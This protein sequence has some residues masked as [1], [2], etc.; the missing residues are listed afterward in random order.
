MKKSSVIRSILAI[1]PALLLPSFLPGAQYLLITRE[2]QY[3]R[4]IDVSSWQPGENFVYLYED[5]GA[6]QPYLWQGEDSLDYWITYDS[7]Y[8]FGKLVGLDLAWMEPAEITNRDQIQYLSIAPDRLSVLKDF[9]NLVAVEIGSAPD[10]ELELDLSP[11][12]NVKNLRA[13]FFLKGEI[14]DE[15]MEIISG[16]SELRVLDLKIAFLP[17]GGGLAP[18]KRLSKL[19]T[20]ILP[21]FP[22][23][24]EAL[25]LSGHQ[26]LES[27][28]SYYTL[29]DTGFVELFK[30]LPQLK[31]L[32]VIQAEIADPVLAWFAESNR[33]EALY[34]PNAGVYGDKITYIGQM[35]NLRALDVSWTEVEDS[36]LV[37][38]A[39]LVNLQ[40]LYLSS[41]YLTDAGVKH[42]TEMKNL[43]KLSLNPEN[44]DRASAHLSGL[45]GITEL[46]FT[47][48]DLT[49]A[50]LSDLVS[51]S[52]L[53][54]LY[55]E[56]PIISDEGLKH[57]R[58]LSNLR[59]VDVS[60]TGVSEEGIARLAKSLPRC[61]IVKQY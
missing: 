4:E 1:M 55:L 8:V 3:E 47:S 42:I 11:L 43:R 48:H 14:T 50:G 25:S 6:Y 26:G 27:L 56:S 39:D 34:L 60:G 2:G 57:L 28:T 9:P 36:Q 35:T 40:E 38:L 10:D 12:S 45:T 23:E 41:I 15:A 5:E 31:E 19:H 29:V 51:L 32:T 21:H 54:V 58:A 53:K 18:L 30:T 52:N 37:H 33:L 44:A 46:R 17:E 59:Y 49:D 7:L 24:E 22:I 20:L 16:L 61:R 13:L